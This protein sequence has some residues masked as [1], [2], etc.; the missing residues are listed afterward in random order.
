MFRATIPV[1]P[2]PSAPALSGTTHC[3]RLPVERSNGTRPGLRILYGINSW[4]V[5]SVHGIVHLET[6]NLLLLWL[7]KCWW[8]RILCLRSFVA[9]MKRVACVMPAIGLWF[10]W[11]IK[12][13]QRLVV[14][15]SSC[16]CV[17][18]CLCWLMFLLRNVFLWSVSWDMRIYK[19]CIALSYHAH[20]GHVTQ[21]NLLVLTLSKYFSWNCGWCIFGKSY[22]CL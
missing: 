10:L 8:Q 17:C 14:M 2:S 11:Y 15:L 4:L 19:I 20:V 16:V 3:S 13:N 21:R 12:G 5:I 18:V 7:S 9:I 22:M 6:P 1:P